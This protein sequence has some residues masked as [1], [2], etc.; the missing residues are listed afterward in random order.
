MLRLGRIINSV[1]GRQAAYC[2]HWVGFRCRKDVW[3]QSTDGEF[4]WYNIPSVTSDH[5]RYRYRIDL[6]IGFASDDALV[7]G[8]SKQLTTKPRKDYKSQLWGTV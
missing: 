3:V 5:I 1:G 2:D 6:A 4:I 7:C 8:R